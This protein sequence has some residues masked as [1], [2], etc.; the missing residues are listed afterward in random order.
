MTFEIFYNEFLF[1]FITLGSGL[2]YIIYNL[3]LKI[4][5]STIDSKIK[6]AEEKIKEELEKKINSI[7]KDR[8]EK[9]KLKLE[10]ILRDISHINNNI[11][12]IDNFKK[13]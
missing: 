12:Q 1:N 13:Y 5:N 11:R 10:P 7:S 8:D 3:I 4:I 6:E 2:I 9:L